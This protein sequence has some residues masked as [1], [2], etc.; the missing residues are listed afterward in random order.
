VGRLDLWATGSWARQRTLKGPGGPI[1]AF[2]WSPDGTSLVSMGDET[3]LLL[4]N[5]RT[6]QVTRTLTGLGGPPTAVGWSPDG[7]LVA[8]VTTDQVL[9]LWNPATGA[10]VQRYQPGLPLYAAAFAPDSRTLAVGGG[11]DT[12]GRTAIWRIA[13]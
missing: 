5:A 11:D 1:W 3:D 7:R 13:P 12:G 8:G 4:W 6:G 2:A 10:V 9:A